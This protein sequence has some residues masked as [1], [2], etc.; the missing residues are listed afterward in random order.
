MKTASLAAL[1]RLQ[2]VQVIC[3]FLLKEAIFFRLRMRGFS[4]S[5]AL[6]QTLN[7]SFVSISSVS[8]L[9]KTIREVYKK[10]GDTFLCR[11]FFYI[12]FPF[13]LTFSHEDNNPVS[14]TWWGW[15][16]RCREPSGRGRRRREWSCLA[17]PCDTLAAP[18]WSRD[19]MKASDWSRDIIEVYD[20]SAWRTLVSLG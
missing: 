1:K 10:K 13:H 18:D 20:W 8:R 5:F 7:L 2:Y 15:R 11:T 14:L 3:I 6:L 17:S 4:G 12:F 16:S 19:I 9:N